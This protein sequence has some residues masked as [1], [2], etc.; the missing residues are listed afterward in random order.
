M[1]QSR[2]G[3]L[4]PSDGEPSSAPSNERHLFLPCQVQQIND[5]TDLGNTTFR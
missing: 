1:G 5:R 3:L 4:D 2:G